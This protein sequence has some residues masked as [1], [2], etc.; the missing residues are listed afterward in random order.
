LKTYQMDHIHFVIEK[1]S[2][3][4]KECSTF[5]GKIS[6]YEETY[7]GSGSGYYKFRK[8]VGSAAGFKDDN[9]NIE[10]KQSGTNKWLRI[11][12]G[13]ALDKEL[14]LTATLSHRQLE[15][16]VSSTG[17]IVVPLIATCLIAATAVAITFLMTK[18][19]YNS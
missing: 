5:S 4:R 18:H 11:N 13:E 12:N 7:D 19:K 2:L 8:D 15:I 9:F 14:K 3:F 16:R 17:G 10:L 1:T 6:H